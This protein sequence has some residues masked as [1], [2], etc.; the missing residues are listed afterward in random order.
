MQNTGTKL[1]EIKRKLSR[2]PVSEL[3]EVN[4]F[5]GFLLSRHM[6]EGR[7]NIHMR[8]VWAGKGFEKIDVQKKIKSLRK[9]ISESI[10]KK[11]K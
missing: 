4:D 5:V 7:R 9:D 2:L 1:V 6:G 3:D 11:G 10:L 8:G